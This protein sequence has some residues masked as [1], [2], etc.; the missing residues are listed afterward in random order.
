VRRG[1][2]IVLLALLAALLAGFVV[3]TIVRL[4]F[5]RPV[6]Y[7]GELV[8][9]AGRPLDV[10]ASLAPVFDAREHEEQIG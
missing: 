6:R 4:R 7:L 9:A 1:V 3:G 10:A 8:P 5:E 2:R